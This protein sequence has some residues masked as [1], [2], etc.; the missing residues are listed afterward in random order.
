MSASRTYAYT[1]GQEHWAVYF[2][3]AQR[4]LARLAPRWPRAVFVLLWLACMAAYVLLIR[5][6]YLLSPRRIDP[7]AFG[8]AFALGALFL[9][10][11]ASVY[12]WL[13]N[14]RAKQYALKPSGLNLGP[15]QLTVDEPGIV[16]RGST[17]TTTIAWRAF[18]EVELLSNIIVLWVEP[19]AGVIVPRDAFDAP[20][21]EA[22][23][24]ADVRA[25]IG[26]TSAHST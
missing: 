9:W 25:R 2:K 1:V 3:A 7:A 8:F 16:S 13:A 21:A 19:I 23:F 14:R 24:L 10:G 6:G 12:F 11:A 5:Y 17:D 15:R 4:R 20:E 18:D 22:A 26:R